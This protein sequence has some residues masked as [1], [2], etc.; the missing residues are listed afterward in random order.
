VFEEG[1]QDF[2]A[3][4]ALADVAHDR[5][6]E[7]QVDDIAADETLEERTSDGSRTLMNTIAIFSFGGALRP[8]PQGDRRHAA[9]NR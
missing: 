8:A 7:V 5:D 2:F 9:T 1:D 4:F 6:E 3:G